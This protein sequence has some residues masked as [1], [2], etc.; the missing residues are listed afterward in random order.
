MTELPTRSQE[1]PSTRNGTPPWE[2]ELLERLAF[3]A[4]TEQRRARRWGIF[5]KLLLVA[6]LVALL[7][8]SWPDLLEAP[9]M[10]TEH[11]ALVDLDGVISEHAPGGA[12]SVISGLRAAFEDSKAKGVLIRINSPG[13]SPVQAGYIYNEIKRL[14]A[15]HPDTPVYAV[16][17]DVCA[18]GGYYVAAAADKI[19]ADP[20]SIVGS[21]GVR[22]DSFGFVGAMD[23]LG[24]ERRLLTAGEHK[25][26]LDPFSP[27][28]PDEVAHLEGLL[29]DIHDEF[30]RRVREGRGGRLAASEQIFS[31][32]IWTGREAKDLGLVDE[33]GSADQIARDVLGAEKIVNHTKKP[34]YLERLAERF[35]IGLGQALAAALGPPLRVQ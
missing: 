11:T 22:M 2:R 14:K 7:A 33:M 29:A 10:V 31:G 8:L 21:I 13:G 1:G 32:L 6:Y 28:K 19:Y 26:L 16:I 35:G 17:T 30:I 25:A 34:D 23:K 18:S 4:V 12:R 15:K 24:V 5:F 9:A 27:T 20:S 3:A